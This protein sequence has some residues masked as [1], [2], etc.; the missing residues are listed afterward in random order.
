M[1]AVAPAIPQGSKAAELVTRFAGEL[2]GLPPKGANRERNESVEFRRRKAL[3]RRFRCEPQGRQALVA[4]LHVLA[5]LAKQGWAVRA[6]GGR[7]RSPGRRKRWTTRGSGSAPTARGAGRAATAAGHTRVRPVDGNSALL[8]GTSSPFIVSS[9]MDRNSP[10]ACAA[11][12]RSPTQPGPSRRPS[13]PSGPTC[14]SRVGTNAVPIRGFASKTSGATSRHTWA[15]RYQTVPGRTMMVLVRDR[16]ADFH[17]VIGIAALSG[18][19]VAV[20]VRNQSIGWTPDR[21]LAEIAAR[22]SASSPAG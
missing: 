8:R 4:A 18:A 14:N 19:A 21:L 1:E 3:S 6:A 11:S 20:T 7:S 15:N 10:T 5:D 9:A 16:A 22:P 2:S 12:A 13:R 17:P